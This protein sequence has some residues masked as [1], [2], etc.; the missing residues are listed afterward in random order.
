MAEADS[1]RAARRLSR[2]LERAARSPGRA[3]GVL[4]GYTLFTTVVSGIL[5]WVL[6]RHDFPTLG[7]GLWWAVQTV[8]TVGYGDVVPEKGVG[9]V[10]GTLVI[11]N[12]IAFL[13]VITAA[14]TAS[15]IEAAR[16]RRQG[17]EQH[18]L[19]AQV[20]DV[21]TRLANIERLLQEQRSPD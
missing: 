10:V 14:V 4:V 1:R 16:R 7:D 17:P 13:T 12:G 6:D 21:N 11:L 19:A 3:I 5:V 8:T 2:S 18:E 15:L 9:R 20:E